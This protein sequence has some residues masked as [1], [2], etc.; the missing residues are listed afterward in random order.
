[1]SRR[2]RQTMK[3]S[4]FGDFVYNQVIPARHFLMQLDKTIDWEPFTAKI[5]ESY[6]GKAERGEVPYNPAII[7]K[8]LLLAYLYAMSERQTEEFCTYYL[9]AKAFLGLGVTEP[10]PDHTTLC[11]FKRRLL[12]HGGSAAYANLFDM[13]I[14]QAQ[15]KGI[16]FGKVQLVDATHTVA[17]VNVE[18]DR[19]RFEQGKPLA[20]P[21]ASVVDKG[22]REV[23]KA[24]LTTQEEKVMHRGYKTHVSMDAET[25]IVTSI[26]P[27]MGNVADNTQMPWL[28]Q[29]DASMGIPAET[30]AADRAYDDGELHEMLKDLKKHSALKLHDFRTNKKDPNKEPWI[31]MLADPFYQ[32]GLQLRYQI[33]RKFGE[34]KASHRFGRCRYRGLDR[35]K[36]QSYLTFMVLNL[37]RIVLLLSKTRFRPLAKHLKTA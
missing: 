30:Y 9:P 33:E 31:K 11:L 15:A 34:A 4:F 14:S 7:L 35:F 1:M 28:V 13:I 22:E 29:K 8:M 23:T 32:D 18:K 36:I 21:D 12:E 2:F 27:T 20:D 24:D 19:K 10:A 25:G 26:K 5:V 37:K 17:D 16:A 3:G 6:K